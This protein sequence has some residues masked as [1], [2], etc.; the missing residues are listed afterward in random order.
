METLDGPTVQA[1]SAL[2]QE[3]HTYILSTTEIDN[4]GLRMNSAVL[5]DRNGRVVFVYDDVFP[6]EWD[7]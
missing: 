4:H 3:H 1:M 6:S 5:L 7:H 2:A